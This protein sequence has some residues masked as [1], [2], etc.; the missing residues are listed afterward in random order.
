MVKVAKEAPRNKKTDYLKYDGDGPFWTCDPKGE[1]V[2]QGAETGLASYKSVPLRTLPQIFDK[3]VELHGDK[4]ALLIEDIPA[5][6]KGEKP[7]PALPLKD[8]K[9]WTYKQYQIDVKKFAKASIAVGLAPFDAINVFG[10]NS[11]Q[12]LIAMYGAIYAGGKVAGIYPSDTDDQVQFKSD[13]SNGTIA[14][15][16]SDMH[17][18]KFK[19][20]LSKLPVLKAIV[21]WDCDPGEDIEVDGRT[22]KT[23]SFEEFL[24][25]GEKEEDTDMNERLKNIKP[26]HGCA[27]V[28]TSGTTG[29]PKAV[30][31]SHDNVSFDAETVFSQA[32][33]SG[34]KESAERILSYLPLSH[35]AGMMLDCVAPLVISAS[36]NYNGYFSTHFARAY[37]LKTGTLGDRLKAVRPTVF[38]GVPRVYEKIMEKLKAVGATT[39]GVKKII[40]N[41]AK[42]R[43]TIYTSSRQLGGTGKTPKSMGFANILLKT[44]KGKLGLDKCKFMISGA[45]PISV[46]VLSYFGALGININEAYGMSETSGVAVFSNNEHHVWGSVGYEVPGTEVKCFTLDG[47][48]VPK[49]KDLFHPTEEEQGEICFRG[50]Q[51]MMGYMAN[52]RLGKDHVEELEKKNEGAIDE[53]GWCHSGDKGTID[54]RGMI[55]ITGRYKELIITAGGENIAPVPIEDELKSQ[56][57]MISNAI[58]IGNKKKFNIMLVT[59]KTVGATGELPGTN[60]LDGAAKHVSKSKL[61]SEAMKDPKF[62]EAITKAITVVNN[63]K[64]VVPSNAAKVQKFTILPRDVSVVTGELTATLKLKRTVVEAQYDPIITKMYEV[65]EVYVPYSLAPTEGVG[66]TET[67]EAHVLEKGL[68][69]KMDK[70]EAE[71][72][73]IAD[74]EEVKE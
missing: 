34:K 42:K 63:N 46:E 50:R 51:I 31:L 60:A 14:V 15:V 47:K 20:V 18:D 66:M 23:Y 19:N 40:A 26:G 6:K 71:A 39:K 21:T 28:Y 17:F 32:L 35:V 3:T 54:T 4:K 65:E 72:E 58:M 12:W 8:W 29:R 38:V 36:S 57:P 59:L 73:K 55:K 61:L 64:N 7:P 9:F 62:A 25:I 68:S 37:D 5:L 16:E 30:Q 69:M 56:C 70:V 74:A 10:F 11:P 49:S 13:H 53:K 33:K 44:I 43:G 52:D 67:N 24:A 22:V 41:Y 45:A 27:L 2:L 1:A 48:E